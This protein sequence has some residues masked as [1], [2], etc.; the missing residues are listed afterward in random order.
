M[1]AGSLPTGDASERFKAAEPPGTV[2]P[3]ERTRDDWA[4]RILPDDAS[5]MASL[6]KTGLFIINYDPHRTLVSVADQLIGLVGKNM[7]LVGEK[8]GSG[9]GSYAG[10]PGTAG[11]VVLDRKSTRLNSSHLGIS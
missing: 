10:S 8:G 6:I 5:K 3:E 11:S 7:G 9:D 4:C 2:L 1:L